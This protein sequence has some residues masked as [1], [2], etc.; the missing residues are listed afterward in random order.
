MA[1]GIPSASRH[2]SSTNSFMISNPSSP[3]ISPSL[4]L[5]FFSMAHSI[6]LDADIYFFIK[7][8]HI[9]EDIAGAATT[10][11]IFSENAPFHQNKDVPV[12]GILRT[13][14]ELRPL[15]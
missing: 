4:V 9:G 7:F 5:A 12:R 3:G 14:G 1:R 8:S 13:L 11:G 2:L 6:A 10:P 15:R